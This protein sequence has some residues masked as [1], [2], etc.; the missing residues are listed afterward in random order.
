MQDIAIDRFTGF[1][2]LY[3]DV[4]PNPPKKVCSIILNLLNIS[5]VNTV[6]DLGSGSG[7]SSRIWKRKAEKII[8]IEPNNDMRSAAKKNNPKL[9]FLNGNSYQ[10]GMKDHSADI[11][12]CSQSFHWMEPVDTLKE[13]NRI[14]KP[15]GIFAVLDCDWPVTIS[16]ESEKAY[17][18]LFEKVYELNR[19]YQDILPKE[20]KWSKNNHLENIIK[21]EYFDYSKEIVFD[22]SEKCDSDRFIGIALSQGQL[23]TLLKN[24]IVEIRKDIDE[25]TTRVKKDIAK[26]KKMLIG[27]RL[28]IAQKKS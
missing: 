9:E 15:K 28:I 21:S 24:N 10:T 23:Q 14:L 20:K 19:R 3:N 16:I 5:R 8:G 27:Y 26:N 12:I 6:V 22:N 18:N 25:F 2:D 17:N 7:L 13:V 1:A 4:R 11:V